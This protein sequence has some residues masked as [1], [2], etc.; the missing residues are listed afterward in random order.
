MSRQAG[1]HRRIAGIPRRHHHAFEPRIACGD[2]AGEDDSKRDQRPVERQF[3][4][5]RRVDDGGRSLF[6]G[7]VLARPM[8][9][10]RSH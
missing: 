6:S 1:G 10:A 7:M 5:E 9:M 4:E 8:A 3:G 2:G